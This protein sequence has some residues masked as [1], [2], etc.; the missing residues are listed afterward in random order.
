MLSKLKLIIKVEKTLNFLIIFH[1]IH[2]DIIATFFSNVFSFELK[3]FVVMHVIIGLINKNH[4][5]L[6]VVNGD[7]LEDIRVHSFFIEFY[8]I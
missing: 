3:T 4:Y 7:W 5:K 6:L 2:H 8:S 1:F